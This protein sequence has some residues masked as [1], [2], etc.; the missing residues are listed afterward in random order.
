MPFGFSAAPVV[1]QNFMNDV[2]Q[3]M[4]KCSNLFGTHSNILLDAP[5]TFEPY[6]KSPAVA[7]ETPSVHQAV[8]MGI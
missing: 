1:L 2:F 3:D 8:E 7:L 4:Q 6:P 5:A